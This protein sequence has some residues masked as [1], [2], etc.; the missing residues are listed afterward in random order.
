MDEL[1]VLTD[2]RVNIL[3]LTHESYKNTVLTISENHRV[4]GTYTIKD[5]FGEFIDR[6]GRLVQAYLVNNRSEFWTYYERMCQMTKDEAFAAAKDYLNKMFVNGWKL[7]EVLLIDELDD[8]EF[9]ELAR[10]VNQ[11]NSTPEGRKAYQDTFVD[12][13]EIADWVENFQKQFS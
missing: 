12:A 6:T 11:R 10:K 1:N 5:P 9:D 4:P 13:A 3:P 7:E 8:D 2:Y